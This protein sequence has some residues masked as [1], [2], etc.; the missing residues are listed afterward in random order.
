MPPLKTG[1]AQYS[2]DLLDVIGSTWPVTV[3]PEPGGN[4]QKSRRLLRSQRHHGDQTA[5]QVAHVGNSGFHQIAFDRALRFQGITVLHDLVLHHARLGAWIRMGKSRDYVRAMEYRYGDAGRQAAR[6]VLRGGAVDLN[7]YPLSEDFLE[8]ASVAIVHSAYSEARA[9]TYAPAATIRVVPMGIPLPAMV[10]RAAARDHLGLPQSAFVITS[11]T[12]VNP[13]KRLH[14]VLRALREVVR[15]F[16][17]TLLVVAGSVAPGMDL[18]RRVAHLGLQQHVRILGYVSDNDSRVLARAGDVAVNLRYPSTGETSA[19]LLRLLG[20]GVP[21]LVTPHGP[22]AD[23]PEDVAV[24]VPVDRFEE[25]LVA[26]YLSWLAQDTSARHEIGASARTYVEQN[27]SMPAA[28]EGYRSAVR[29]AFGRELPPIGSGNVHEPPPTMR[30]TPGRPRMATVPTPV[31]AKVADALSDI[32]LADHD[33]TIQSVAQAMVNIGL[34]GDEMTP[35]NDDSTE[36]SISQD[37]VNVLACPACK[38]G[39]RLED[40]RI[41]CESCGRRYPVENG[42][43]VMIVEESEQPLG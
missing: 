17:E 14:I 5:D 2:Q 33:G 31:E 34:R 19:S 30:V 36:R 13:Y 11:I 20:A 7:E 6:R 39:V 12:H 38:A 23:I 37:L 15:H 10:D 28:V 35:Q 27:H 1:I 18:E 8:A 22:T 4:E 41:V 24:R 43:P 25:E 42:I 29:E 40:D 32:G 16:P 9:L 26:E 21:V 3:L